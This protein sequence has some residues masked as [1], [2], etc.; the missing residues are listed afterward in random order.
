MRNVQRLSG[1]LG[2]FIS[3][4]T[5]IHAHDEEDVLKQHLIIKTWAVCLALTV[6]PVLKLKRKKISIYTNSSNTANDQLHVNLGQMIKLK[7]GEGVT[8]NSLP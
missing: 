1:E 6:L 4:I 3:V 5:A 2:S 7:P 8:L